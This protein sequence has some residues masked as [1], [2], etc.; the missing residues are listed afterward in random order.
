MRAKG[1]V[2]FA[3]NEKRHAGALSHL[4]VDKWPPGRN[5]GSAALATLQ[6]VCSP[7]DEDKE[8]FVLLLD[9]GKIK[10]QG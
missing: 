9:S 2:T 6:K 10:Q 3:V 7:A 1:E 4:Q 8:V 5:D